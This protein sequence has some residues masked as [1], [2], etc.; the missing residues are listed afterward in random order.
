MWMEMWNNEAALNV[1]Q[2]NRYF[3]IS[4][5]IWT[6][7]CANEI[8]TLCRAYDRRTTGNYNQWYR[9]STRT[10]L[11]ATPPP[12]LANLTRDEQLLRETERSSAYHRD[13]TVLQIVYIY[14]IIMS[15][16]KLYRTTKY[17]FYLNN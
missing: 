13:I 2:E 10:L 8:Y 1:V 15:V 12:R 7:A 17:I 6:R 14:K 5:Y 16:I 11:A 9:S 4:T 3:I